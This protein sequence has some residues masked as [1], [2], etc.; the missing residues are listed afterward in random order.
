M[1]L[2]R[3]ADL[4]TTSATSKNFNLKVKCL[5]VAMDLPVLKHS[6]TF[7]AIYSI[8][9]RHKSILF[10]KWPILIHYTIYKRFKQIVS[11]L[12]VEAFQ[13]S[14]LFEFQYTCMT[15]ICPDCNFLP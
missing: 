15:G 13:N 5:L 9:D 7:Q 10:S 14:P 12:F 4:M 2:L 8:C 3:R 6:M 1:D 11:R